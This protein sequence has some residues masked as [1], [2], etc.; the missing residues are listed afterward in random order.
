FV[1]IFLACDQLNS[2]CAMEVNHRANYRTDV[3]KH[4][5]ETS[6]RKKFSQA[7]D[8]QRILRGSVDPPSL[9]PGCHAYGSE[10]LWVSFRSA[11]DIFTIDFK[12]SAMSH[13]QLVNASA[14]CSEE[15]VITNVHR[16]KYG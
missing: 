1:G 8:V 5:N 4:M 2:R 11:I 13:D 7:A 6:L 9:R 10:P 15:F 14:E 16:A 12:M 3:A